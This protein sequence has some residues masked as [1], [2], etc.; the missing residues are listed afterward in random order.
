VSKFVLVEHY[1]RHQ[2]LQVERA[3]KLFKEKMI[4]QKVDSRGIQ[5]LVVRKVENPET[6]K[7]SGYSTD[8]SWELWNTAAQ[9]YMESIKALG[10]KRIMEILQESFNL[11]DS[12]GRRNP[13][14]Q[15]DRETSN[16]ARTA[17]RSDDEDLETSEWQGVDDAQYQ[18]DDDNT[19]T[20]HARTREGAAADDSDADNLDRRPLI[21]ACGGTNDADDFFIR[22]RPHVEASESED[23]DVDQRPRPRPRKLNSGQQK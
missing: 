15:V 4:E 21:P 1:L 7:S 23:E 14:V 6:K 19:S 17:L 10:D 22:R 8:F 18:E 3:V 16:S 20:Q 2:N 11:T 13:F 12:L 9:Q 5:R